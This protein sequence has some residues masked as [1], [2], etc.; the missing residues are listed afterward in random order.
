M[1][2]SAFTLIEVVVAI[3]IVVVIAAIA[4]PVFSSARE[5]GRQAKCVSNL[6]QWG[7]AIQMYRQEWDGI[8]PAVGL[9]ITS[10]YQLG[11]PPQSTKDEFIHSYRLGHHDVY[12]CPSARP[13]RNH[14][15]LSYR[16]YYVA[17][18]DPP[19]PVFQAFFDRGSEVPLLAC[20]YHNPEPWAE[21]NPTYGT[22][23]VLALRFNQ[24]VNARVIKTFGISSP[25]W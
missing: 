4:V 13:I 19:P 8:D 11:L 20:T 21:D 24:S 25:Y 23:K 18:A 5:N 7:L 16:E 22:W 14:S 12:F 1:R 9:R 15:K 6:H 10:L 2:K 3:A 17:Y